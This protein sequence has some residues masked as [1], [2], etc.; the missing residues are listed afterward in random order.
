[1]KPIPTSRRE[2][3]EPQNRRGVVVI[4]IRRMQSTFLTRAPQDAHSKLAIL[5][6]LS[7]SIRTSMSSEPSTLTHDSCRPLSLVGR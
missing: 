3:S 6:P 5:A 7:Q 1:M 4:V 2:K